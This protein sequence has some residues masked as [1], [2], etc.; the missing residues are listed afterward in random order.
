MRTGKPHFEVLAGKT[1]LFVQVT[2]R[3]VGFDMKGNTP[4]GGLDGFFHQFAA[5]SFSA[6]AVVNRYIHEDML[7]DVS[8]HTRI[9]HDDRADHPALVPARKD[10]TAEALAFAQGKING[11]ADIR[12]SVTVLFKMRK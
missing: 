10:K 2:C 8:L 1:Q 7:G 3:V 4:G 5:V 11:L 9:V 6:L 12:A